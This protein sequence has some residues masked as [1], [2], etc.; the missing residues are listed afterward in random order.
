MKDSFARRGWSTGNLTVISPKFFAVK[1]CES[2]DG[3][4]SGGCWEEGCV[5]VADSHAFKCFPNPPTL[6]CVVACRVM[7][8]GMLFPS[9]RFQ[10]LRLLH[11]V[12][13]LLFRC[14][15]S[16]MWLCGHILVW[17]LDVC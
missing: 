11:C 17:G 1:C 10:P 12:L 7:P 13:V 3:W 6:H 9:S 5:V 8:I 14:L 4:W 15:A 2:F 16:F